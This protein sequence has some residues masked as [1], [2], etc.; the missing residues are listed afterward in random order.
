MPNFEAIAIK[1]PTA[2]ARANAS[3]AI[4]TATINGVAGKRIVI[5]GYDVSTSANPTVNTCRFQLT[6]G[7][8]TF[9]DFTIGQGS[10]SVVW[11]N[12]ARIVAPVNT[13]VTATLGAAGTSITGYITL[14]FFL[15]DA[16]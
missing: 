14:R 7:T 16:P 11:E 6:D 1:Y 4:A 5:N 9:V 13:T 12:N 15:E 8:T 10:G 2:T 3:N